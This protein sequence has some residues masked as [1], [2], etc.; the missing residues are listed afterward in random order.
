MRLGMT[1]PDV[2]GKMSFGQKWQ[3]MVKNDLKM[4]LAKCL[5]EMSLDLAE[6][7]VE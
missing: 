2:L 3:Q 5:W 1:K 6:I 4:G 7:G